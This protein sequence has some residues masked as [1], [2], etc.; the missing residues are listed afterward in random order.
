M[1]EM[2]VGLRAEVPLGSGR[3]SG[4]GCEAANAFRFCIPNSGV[5][6]GALLTYALF[7]LSSFSATA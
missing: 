1:S 6:K 4:G 5:L 7:C 3:S 2:E